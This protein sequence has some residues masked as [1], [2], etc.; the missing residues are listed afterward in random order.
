MTDTVRSSP[1]ILPRE[2]KGLAICDACLSVIKPGLYF[3][4]HVDR[5]STLKGDRKAESFAACCEVCRDAVYE[6]RLVEFSLT[7][8]TA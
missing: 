1:A 3:L 4:I 7:G 8:V 2:L 6:E 5:R